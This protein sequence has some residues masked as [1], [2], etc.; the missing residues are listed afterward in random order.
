MR[1][2]FASETERAEIVSLRCS[3]NGVMAKPQ[4]SRINVGGAQ[5]PM[6]RCGRSGRSISPTMAS[7]TRRPT[8]ALSLRPTTGS[9]A[10]R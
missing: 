7:L 9:M 4:L 6:A 10:R 1:Y 5:P 2:G 8:I 3:V